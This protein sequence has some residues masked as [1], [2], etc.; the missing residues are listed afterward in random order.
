MYKDLVLDIG[1][2]DAMFS[3]VALLGA[4]RV[5]RDASH[6]ADG[7]LFGVG[8]DKVLF[9][10]D[11]G[12]LLLLLLLLLRRSEM[13][14]LVVLR[15]D[16]ANVGLVKGRAFGVQDLIVATTQGRTTVV[17]MLMLMFMRVV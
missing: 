1:P 16:F 7:A 14:S 8:G 2:L 17:E 3:S 6:L 12:M 5:C 15:S 4:G 11:D 10:D 9:V 13:M